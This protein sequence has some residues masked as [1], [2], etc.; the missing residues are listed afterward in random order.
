MS[1]HIIK[2][3]NLVSLAEEMIGEIKDCWKEPFNSPTV[4]F[5]DPLMEN[6]FKLY[7]LEKNKDNAVLMNLRI[8]RLDSFLFDLLRPSD[9]NTKL[10]M[11]EMLHLE[12]IKELSSYEYSD[13]LDAELKYIFDGDKISSIRLYDFTKSLAAL[14]IDYE[15]TRYEWFD[16]NGKVGSE[17]SGWQ[18]ALY[19]KVCKNGITIND[20]EY[21]TISELY[22]NNGSK[23]PE[24]KDSNKNCFVFGFSGMGQLYRKIIAELGKQQGV[25]LH[26]Y[27]QT[28][29]E[30]DG[31]KLIGKLGGYG[32]ANYNEWKKNSIDSDETPS[33]GICP[34]FKLNSAPS[35]VREVEVLHS[36]ICK[37]INQ[38]QNI[39]FNDIKVFAPDI[40]EYIPAVNLVFGEPMIP[41]EE[42]ERR[43][44]KAKNLNKSF[45]ISYTINDFSSTLSYTAEALNTLVGVLHKGFFSRVDFLSL[46]KNPVIQASYGINEDQT[47][48]WSDWIE[49]MNIF[50]R[51][52]TDRLRDD[53]KKA[54]QRLLLSRISDLKTVDKD[55][56]EILPFDTNKDNECIFGFVSLIDDLYNWIKIASKDTVS[57]SDEDDVSEIDVVKDILRKILSTGNNTD[58][59]LSGEKAVYSK[60]MS[61]IALV[62]RV[63]KDSMIDRK[64]LILS[65]L[66]SIS[67]ISLSQKSVSKGIEFISFR[68]NRVIPAKYV[69]FL[70]LDSDSFPGLETKS[71][72]DRRKDKQNGDDFIPDKNKNAFLC[73]LFATSKYFC[74]SYVNMDLKKDEV[75]YPSTV[76]NDLISI[77][78]IMDFSSGID[79]KKEESAS[80][81]LKNLYTFRR[82]R[83][84]KTLFACKHNY[85]SVSAGTISNN[86]EANESSITISQFRSYLSE[87]FR[88]RIEKAFSLDNKNDK[89]KLE[90]EPIELDHLAEYK[91]RTGF[92]K[93][94]DSVDIIKE[95]L[96]NSDTL[97]D[98]K[99]GEEES[100]TI[101]D[102]LNR[103]RNV[104]ILH[105]LYGALSP[106]NGFSKHTD[107]NQWTVESKNFSLYSIDFHKT[108]ELTCLSDSEDSIESITKAFAKTYITALAA[109]AESNTVETDRSFTVRLIVLIKN[110]NELKEYKLDG[111]HFSYDDANKLLDKLF[112]DRWLQNGYDPAKPDNAPK[113]VDLISLMIDLH[114]TSI[115]VFMKDSTTYILKDNKINPKID[116]FKAT[117]N[118]SL[119][120]V[121]KSI[122]RRFDGSITGKELGH[123]IE[124]L[125]EDSSVLSSIHDIKGISLTLPA[126]KNICFE[127]NE[128]V[129]VDGMPDITGN[130]SFFNSNFIT[131]RKLSCYDIKSGSDLSDFLNGYVSSLVL[132]A[133]ISDSKEL[134]IK[135]HVLLFLIAP[136]DGSISA[137]SYLISPQE[138]TDKLKEIYL[139]L[140]NEKKTRCFPIDV[141][142][143]RKMEEP[144]YQDLADYLLNEHGPWGYFTKSKLIDITE[145]LGYDLEDPRHFS[146]QWKNE[147]MRVENL[148]KPLLKD[149]K[150]E[151]EEGAV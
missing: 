45:S 139:S 80:E 118:K 87:P 21:K 27:L 64:C 136:K 149:S 25:T 55:N 117:E 95:N 44:T 29:T 109:I 2:S 144:D 62:K 61:R 67:N 81:G 20:V 138:A 88:Y 54:K 37:I 47:S 120:N 18:K 40:K 110:D 147:R 42:A 38:N 135:Y 56:V 52:K 17:W 83:N 22:F 63:Y 5:P 74:M 49:E 82:L 24:L 142:E 128:A 90:L 86:S 85:K 8:K 84:Y 66:D 58:E 50:R 98:G 68:P 30:Q 46:I 9:G 7:W 39:S 96:K 73:Q 77:K 10:L 116:G 48:T 146:A 19:E 59:L 33:R 12:L 133:G 124:R 141:L 57:V 112:M 123:E 151:S 53:W 108:G 51:R 4:I 78:E 72:L 71:V 100:D 69:F 41:E 119:N 11:P 131:E 129:K 93:N 105:E 99:Y 15:I 70:G 92:L 150:S 79:E 102:S 115:P 132:L 94:G 60:M 137:R 106:F 6:W 76:I 126:I 145:G 104:F 107:G 125:K 34:E 91:I 130:Y 3:L 114:K 111:M 1:L 148:V 97:P 101:V 31:D 14:F 127:R 32:T 75:F 89:E 13:K 28:E 122:I 113:R 16:G 121:M 143:D 134:M 23:V 26:L 65:L 35:K 36:E 103:I 43:R 140:I